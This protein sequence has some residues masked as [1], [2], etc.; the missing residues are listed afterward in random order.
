MKILMVLEREF[1]PDDRVEKEALSLIN[2]GFEVH[3]A[4]YSKAR[5]FIKLETYKNIFIHRKYLPKIIYKLS[6]VILIFPFYFWYWIAYLKR[7]NRTYHF[8]VIHI[9]DLPLAKLGYNFKKHQ[10]LHF[11]A[12]QHEYYSNWIIH[13]AHYNTFLGKII[14]ILSPWSFYEKKYLKKAD[15]V[16]T[17]ERPLMKTYIEEH[18]ISHEKIIC[19]PNTPLKDNFN[20]E[21]IST[22][23][24]EK[25]NNKF[26]IIYVG[27]IDILRGIDLAISALPELKMKIPNVKLLLIGPCYGGY[28]PMNTARKFDVEEYVEIAGWKSINLVPSYIAASDIGIFTPQ[29]NRDE[30][31]KTIATKIY[32]YIAMGKPVIVGQAKLMKQFVQM[33]NLGLVVDETSPSDFVQAIIRIYD[34]PVLQKQLSNNCIRVAKKYYW[35]TTSAHLIN[36]YFNINCDR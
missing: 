5:E 3:V 34:D 36:S 11:V 25:Y 16:I 35:E 14:K 9:H 33:N 18:R 12:D 4:C 23:I 27:G 31:N 7:L 13:T 30:I 2:S 1:P 24:I 32:Q 26:V 10:N 29:V 15:M 20:K 21:N 6:A 22:D 17:V 19:L 8:D 28:D